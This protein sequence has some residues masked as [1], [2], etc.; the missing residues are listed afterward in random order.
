MSCLQDSLGKR[1]KA[2]NS[3]DAICQEDLMGIQEEEG[4]E[5]WLARIQHYPSADLVLQK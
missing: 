5:Q 1:K 4:I 3:G 2:G